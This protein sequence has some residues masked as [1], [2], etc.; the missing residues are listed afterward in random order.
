[1]RYWLC[2]CAAFTMA[3]ASTNASAKTVEIGFANHTAPFVLPDRDNPGIAVEI[4]R[5]AFK[6]VGH[7]VRPLLQSWKRIKEEVKLGRLD[8]AAGAMPGGEEGLYYSEPCIAFDNMAIVRE[9]DGI[10]IRG[11]GDLPGHSIVAW[12]DAHDHLGGEFQKLFGRHVDADYVSRYFDLADQAA[13]VRMFW[14][15]RADV[16]V[17]D[18]VIFDYMTSTMVDDFDTT[19]EVRRHRIFGGLTVFSVAFSDPELRD[20]FDQG[21]VQLRRRGEIERIYAKYRSVDGR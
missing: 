6:A 1:M 16:I 13:Q 5:E 20:Q 14:S 17:I 10:D 11:I 4:V 7:D 18:D 12:Q 19:P 15:G 2:L 3:V 8:A 9:R 21:L